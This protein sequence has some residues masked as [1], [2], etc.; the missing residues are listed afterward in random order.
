M[1]QEIKE[2]MEKLLDRTLY[3]SDMVVEMRTALGIGLIL[4]IMPKEM[5]E[6]LINTYFESGAIK[7]YYLYIN[8]EEITDG[9]N[10]NPYR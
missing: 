8:G 1:E 2:R 9:K 3:S 10:Y 6:G 7:G 5:K 4:G